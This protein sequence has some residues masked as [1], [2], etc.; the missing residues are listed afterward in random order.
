MQISKKH[1]RYL[2]LILREKLV[3]GVKTGI[4]SQ[5]G[6]I[7]H[8]RGEAF[9]YL[10][11][12]KTNGFAKQA[13]TASAALLILSKKPIL[14]ING[15][16]AAL[17]LPEF[18]RLARL[19]DCQIEVN[20]FHFSQ[21]RVSKIET[22]LKKMDPKRVLIAKRNEKIVIAGINSK[23]A[24]VLGNGI[25]ES[26][27]V[28]VPLEDGDRCEAL[29]SLGKKVITIDLNPMSRT[30][31]TAT[32]TIVDNIVRS[33]NLLLLEIKRLKNKDEKF[34]ESIINKYDNKKVIAAAISKISYHRFK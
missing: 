5:A 18:I 31:R 8:G 34:L 6:L 22:L 32:I 2:S 12:E 20:L 28:L 14:S 4:T 21:K 1:P 7:A 10:L 15:N 30:A 3:R 27:C 26:D 13:I 23:R 29:I 17:S 9:D 24:V 33:L 19:L 25:G 16:S 11:G